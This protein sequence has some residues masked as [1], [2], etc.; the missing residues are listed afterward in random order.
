MSWQQLARQ[1]EVVLR[2]HI[3]DHPTSDVLLALS[4][5]RQFTCIELTLSAGQ[6]AGQN[7]VVGDD[8]DLF[9]TLRHGADTLRRLSTTLRWMSRLVS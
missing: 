6:T 5:T 9:V 3:K 8:P 7:E 4:L 2:G 1:G